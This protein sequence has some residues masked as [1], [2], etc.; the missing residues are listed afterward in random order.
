MMR[1]VLVIFALLAAAPA[2]AQV[3]TLTGAGKATAGYIGPTLDPGT[4]T[5][6]TLSNGNLTATNTGTTSQDQG[7]HTPT[8]TN[9]KT[10]G[11]FYFEVTFDTVGVS[12]SNYGFGVGRTTSTY[13]NMGFNAVTGNMIY[14]SG[15]IWRN[16]INSGLSLG[17][18]ASGD[19]IGMAVDIGNLKVW[20]KKVNGTPT[21]WN[22]VPTDNP[23]TNTGGVAMPSLSGASMI[24]FVTFGGTGGVASRVM[25]AN[26]GASVFVGT[27]PSGFT[28][29]WT[30]NFLLA[31]DINP[32]N[33]NVPMFLPRAA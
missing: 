6:V 7:A 4:V 33:D 30:L 27:V 17:V 5:A 28:S 15:N 21:D 25:T 31:S 18:R 26:F 10:S 24:P 3:M 8:T 19:V 14:S 12:G 11:K 29:G 20:Y 16:G 13:T 22:G 9:N 1:L 32:A 2:N 23:A